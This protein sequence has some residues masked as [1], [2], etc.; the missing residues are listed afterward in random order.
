MSAQKLKPI[1]QGP[2]EEDLD[3]LDGKTCFRDIT[4]VN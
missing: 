4:Y 1:L 3:D 2:T